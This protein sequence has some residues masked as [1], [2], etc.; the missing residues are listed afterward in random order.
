MSLPRSFF[1]IAALVRLVAGFGRFSRLDLKPMH[2]DE[3]VNHHFVDRFL[4][5]EG[6]AYSPDNFH[7]PLLYE[8]AFPVVALLGDDETVLRAMPA[9]MGLVAVVATLAAAPLVGPVGVLFGASV[10]AVA[11]PDVYFSRTFIHEVYLSLFLIATIVFGLRFLRDARPRDLHGTLISLVA[12]FAIKETT[13]I[14]V[15]GMAAGFAVARVAG[16]ESP[17]GVTFTNP[18][19]RIGLRRAL[20]AAGIALIVW[21]LMFTTFGT[22][23]RGI[24]DFF[25]AYVPWL[26]TGVSDTGHV[27]SAI[28]F[29]RLVLYYYWPLL[30]AAVPA[31]VDVARTRCRDSIFFL[32]FFAVQLAVYSAI[33]YKTPW[34]VMPIVVPLVFLAAIGVQTA[35]RI[36]EPNLAARICL[37][38]AMPAAVVAIGSYS[39]KVN[40]EQYD[41]DREPIVYVQTLRR[42]LEMIPVIDAAAKNDQGNSTEILIVDYQSPTKYYLRAYRNKTYYANAPELPVT[43]PV[44][45]ASKSYADKV[46]EKLASP[47]VE[48][49]YPVWPGM[50]L[51]LFVRED[52]TADPTKN[53]EPIDG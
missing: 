11:A 26:K 40:F 22:N 5:G 37:A 48:S 12:A 16:Y 10:L 52:L 25:V 30:I 51:V 38:A 45:I 15:L 44:V 43:T 9:V 35:W 34:C 31:L 36:A 32:T 6:Y 2:H 4:I 7:G 8:I 20:D 50:E 13:A 47:Y 39:W 28:Y 49:R 27:K 24:V 53:G 42:Y 46:R 1:L 33:P 29:P 18:L 41:E 3:G 21:I 19:P 23:P 17:S 14:A